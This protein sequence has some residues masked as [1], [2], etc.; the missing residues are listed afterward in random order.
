MCLLRGTDRIIKHEITQ[1][2]DLCLLLC[3]AVSLRKYFPN[4]G[5]VREKIILN[6]SARKR[7]GPWTGY[8]WLGI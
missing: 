2:E 5:R 6:S 4:F 8:I 7:M 1:F 3:D